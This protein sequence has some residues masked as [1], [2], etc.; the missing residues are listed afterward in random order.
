MHNQVIVYLV[1]LNGIIL[2]ANIT[3]KD[4]F[5]VSPVSSLILDSDRTIASIFTLY[6]EV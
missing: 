1:V 5:Q 2:N 3:C 6:F 4:Q